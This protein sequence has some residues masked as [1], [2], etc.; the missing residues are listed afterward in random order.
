[1]ICSFHSKHDICLQ[2]KPENRLA[3][4]HG[5][6]GYKVKTKW[7]NEGRLAWWRKVLHLPLLPN[8]AL[9]GADIGE[10]HDFL[11]VLAAIAPET[12]NDMG[13]IRYD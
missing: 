8:L 3:F 9:K 10:W 4:Y 2:G 13:P 1:L 5:G 6:T 12:R 7:T 11:P